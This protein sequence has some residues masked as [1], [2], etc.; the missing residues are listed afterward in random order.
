MKLADSLIIDA[1]PLLPG[2]CGEDVIGFFQT[3]P[4]ASLCPI[5]DA[6][7]QVVGHVSRVKFQNRVAQPFG[8]TFV[9]RKTVKDLTEPQSRSL[10]R[11]AQL[12]TLFEGDAFETAHLIQDGFV[13]VDDDGLYA[14]LV[15]GIGVLAAL[16]ELA[17]G[18]VADLK[19]E[20]AE[21][22]RAEERIRR[23]AET[24]PL[25]GLGNRR[26]Y[27]RSIEGAMDRDAPFACVFIDLDRFKSLN[28]QYG[29]AAGDAVLVEVSKRVRDFKSTLASAR[30]G[31]DEFAL[32]LSQP[33][34]SSVALMMAE[35][36]DCVLRPVSVG[37]A[38]VTVGASIGW[39]EFPGD[40]T[41]PAQLLHAADKAMLRIKAAGGGTTRFNE[42]L[43]FADLN[44]TKL[45]TQLRAAVFADAIKPALQ[46]VADL[47]TG[48][49][50][51]HEVF[52][53]W[54]NSGFSHD[55]SPSAFIPIAERAAFIDPLFWSIA[56]QVF[57]AHPTPQGF[58]ALNV[59]PSQLNATAFAARMQIALEEFGLS[60][61]QI[62]LEVTENVLVRDGDAVVRTLNQLRDLGVRI[63]LDDFGTGYASLAMLT[64]LPLDKVKIDSCFVAPSEEHQKH[65]EGQ[66]LEATIAL[67]RKLGFQ[68]C[69]EG[70]EDQQTLD[71]LRDLG[72]DLAQGYFI[73][74]PALLVPDRPRRVAVA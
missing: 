17:S 19:R 16:N 61:E 30:L 34:P 7:R 70:V 65:G 68:S 62:E 12:E 29:H 14:G 50:V 20:V 39:A 10:L 33:E 60:G 41:T 43:D 21:R 3:Y 63:C 27:L 26:A 56:R 69:A 11:N 28:D 32:I 23:L 74:R 51:G 66:I 38:C 46:P 2:D 73:G 45:E 18:L 36:H 47:H 8:R 49:I 48:E 57:D 5:V 64:R 15:T 1:R 4:N 53:R 24:D 37:N 13:V 55:P 72:C 31:G 9:E 35:L 25:T 67:C 42:T 22:R 54:P 71:R 59:S 40:A 44:R 6:Q 52:A 58:L